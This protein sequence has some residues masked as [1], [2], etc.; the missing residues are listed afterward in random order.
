M[1]RIL[2]YFAKLA[3]KQMGK[4]S[5]KGVKQPAGNKLSRKFEK[6]TRRGR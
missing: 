1:S 3:A 2:D 5:Q 4:H 6:A